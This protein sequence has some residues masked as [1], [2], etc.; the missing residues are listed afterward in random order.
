ML[1]NDAGQAVSFFSEQVPKQWMDIFL[2]ESRHPVFE[3]ELLP[4]TVALHV[5]ETELQYCQEVFYLDNEAAKGALIAGATP[6]DN[7]SWLVRSFTVREM[8]CQLKVWFARVPTSSN[9]ADKPSRLDVSELTAEGVSRATIKWE[10]LLELI[11]KFRSVDW[12]EGERD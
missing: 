5:W 10:Q 11:R 8:L 6:S 7:G 4:V 3:L 9:V 1:V 12:G 2:A